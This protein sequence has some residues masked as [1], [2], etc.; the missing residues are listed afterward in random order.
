MIESTHQDIVNDD[1]DKGDAYLSQVKYLTG[2]EGSIRPAAVTLGCLQFK[3][4]D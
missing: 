4:N 3:A 1:K 2:L